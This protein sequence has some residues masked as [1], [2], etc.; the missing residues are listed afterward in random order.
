[1]RQSVDCK[2]F[3]RCKSISFH[4]GCV[5]DPNKF[6]YTF[7]FSFKSQTNYRWKTDKRDECWHCAIQGGTYSASLPM[8]FWFSLITAMS[9]PMSEALSNLAR[10]AIIFQWLICLCKLVSCEVMR[11]LKWEKV[12]CVKIVHWLWQKV[13][14]QCFLFCI[15]LKLAIFKM[16]PT[17]RIYSMYRWQRL[18]GKDMRI[19]LKKSWV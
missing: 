12:I 7:C 1:M 4:E 3:A 9:E 16:S 8:N 15:T 18:G 14:S 10:W 5:C 11:T 19:S 13:S 2:R 17:S 6:N